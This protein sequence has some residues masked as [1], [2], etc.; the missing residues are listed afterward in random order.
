MTSEATWELRGPDGEVK[1]S[2][3]SEPQD[4]KEIHR[5]R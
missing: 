3:S 5:D 1:A 2:G 4:K